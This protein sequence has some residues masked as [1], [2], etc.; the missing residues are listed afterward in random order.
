VRDFYELR[1]ESMARLFGE[2]GWEITPEEPLAAI[3][4][5]VL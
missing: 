1:R 2:P 4:Y 5:R 3:W